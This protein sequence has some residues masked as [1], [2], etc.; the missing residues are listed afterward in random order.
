M[1]QD[2]LVKNIKK[3]C[4]EKEISLRMLE[5]DLE[6][7]PGLISR[8]TRMN[9]SIAKIISVADYLGVSVDELLGR[10]TEIRQLDFLQK[11]LLDTKNR[12]LIWKPLGCKVD[13]IS[14]L[15]FLREIRET[16]W[17]CGYCEFKEACFLIEGFVDSDEKV[18]GLKIY[19]IPDLDS[20][21]VLQDIDEEEILPLFDE[22]R[23]D[24]IWRCDENK[25]EKIRKEF[26][27]RKEY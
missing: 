14:S 12:K 19:I 1:E 18:E 23:N 4:G 6:F 22:I 25:A 2:S 15:Q 26:L 11:L 17:V 24:I 5:A 27:K 9:P 7:S 16:G 8:W 3:I 20:A 13:F 21:P 10:A